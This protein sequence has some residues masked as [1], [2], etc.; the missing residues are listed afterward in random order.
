MAKSPSLAS[1]ETVETTTEFGKDKKPD[2]E[3]EMEIRDMVSQ[4][5]KGKTNGNSTRPLFTP[6]KMNF[7]LVWNSKTEVGKSSESFER[8]RV[9]ES[10]LEKEGLLLE[11]EEPEANG[12]NF[13]KVFAPQNVLKRYA[14]ILKL[15]LPMRKFEHISEIRVDEVKIPIFSDVVSG[16]QSGLHKFAEPFKYDENKFKTRVNEL[17]ATFSRDKEYLF[18]VDADFFT[19]SMRSRIIEFIL[20]R[21]RLTEDVD[22]E[23][24]FGIDKCLADGIYIAAYPLHDGSLK[25]EEGMRYKLFSEWASFSKIFKLQPLDAVRDYFGV[26]IALYFAWLGFYTTLLIPPAIMGLL[27]FLYGVASMGRDIP[28][29]DICTMS[30]IRICPACDHFCDYWSLDETCLHSKIMYLFDNETTVFFAIFMSF[31]AALFLEFWKRYSSEIAH[32]WDVTGYRPEEE[33]P[34]PEYLAQL[35]NV[36]ERTVN[37]VTQTTEPRVPFWKMRFPGIVLSVSTVLLMV[38]MGL[39]AVI[40]VI[41]YRMSMGAAL[42]AFHEETIKGHASLFISVTGATINLICILIFNQIYGYVAVWLTDL[43][44]NRTQTEFDDSL[45]L[46]IYLLQ[47]VNYYASIFYIAFFKGKFV[48]YPGGYNRFL[49]HRQEECSPGGCFMELC[50]QMAIIFVGKQFLLSVVEYHLPRIWKIFNTIKVIS[51]LQKEDQTRYPQWVQD[52]RLV[53]FGQQGLFYEYLEMVIQYGFI[54]I[55]VSAFPLAPLFALVNN[56]FELRLDAKKLLVHHRRPVAQ[57]VK[58]IGIWL[59]IMESLGKISVVTN[60]FIIAFTSE[61][62]PKM[63]YRIGYSPDGTLHGYT[64]FTLSVFDPEDFEFRSNPALARNDSMTHTPEFCRYTDFRYPPGHS[65]EYRI[66]EIYWHIL[67]ARLAFVVVFQN[68]VALS[69][70]AIKWVVPNMSTELKERIRREAYLTNEIII[71]TELLKAKGEL[72]LNMEYEDGNEE[73]SPEE[74]IRSNGRLLRR[75]STR[76]H[77]TGDVT[78]GQIVV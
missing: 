32:R 14:E 67:A 74:S 63:A 16:L 68:F 43:E 2:E 45:S 76:R 6:D 46:K 11:Y 12:L 29:Q 55:F 65:K 52:F 50:L 20:K 21:K 58:D 59:Q 27:V 49:G 73:Q 30:D 78:D 70:M 9:F 24:A 66:N 25:R 28:S 62:I 51:G 1:Q 33:H 72:D 37:F 23:F 71:R 38:L 4:D 15:R 26:K 54:T 47:F 8:R 39:V 18:D 35:R 64:N 3:I 53:E 61:F 7:I 75:R 56:V 31:W 57:R 13:V 60:G 48:G 44:L 10:N 40:G 77:E 22:D 41:V 5:E 17:T 42:N 19:P 34:R 36:K 69:L